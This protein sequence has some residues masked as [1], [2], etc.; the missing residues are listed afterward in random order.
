MY[1]PDEKG[2][3]I[4]NGKIISQ[5]PVPDPYVKLFIDMGILMVGTV[6]ANVNKS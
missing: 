1:T 4:G 5:S 6:G 2:L 3:T